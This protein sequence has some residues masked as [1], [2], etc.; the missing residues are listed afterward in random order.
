M[1]G[2]E[3]AIIT[4]FVADRNFLEGR[5]NC[6][7]KFKNKMIMILEE[8]EDFLF[9]YQ[10]PY[11]VITK[12]EI[13]VIDPERNLHSKIFLFGNKVDESRYSLR[14][15]IGSCNATISGFFRNIEFWATTTG[16]LDMPNTGK[17][18]LV[19]LLTS[20]D[21]DPSFISLEN[22]CKEEGNDKILSPT[23]DL[24]WRLIR[25][26]KGLDS[27]LEP[28]RSFCLS[29]KLV[30]QRQI[31]NA[32]FVHSL[33]DNSLWKAFEHMITS[34]LQRAEKE[35]SILVVSP[36]HNWQALRSL[37]HL[38]KR[39]LKNVNI[40]VQIK[41]LT[42]F[43][44][45]FQNRYLSKEA[46][47]DIEKL[48]IRDKKI[49]FICKVWTRRSEIKV[50]ELFEDENLQDVSSVFL[51]GKLIIVTNDKGECQALL[52]SPN[53][54][55][56]AIS[57]SPKLNLETAIW[58]RNESRAKEILSKAQILW[59]AA[60]NLSQNMRERLSEWQKVRSDVLTHSQTWIDSSRVI[61]EY[62][63]VN[64]MKK[65][66]PTTG[67]NVFLDELDDVFL[68][69][70]V[71]KGAPK[72]NLKEIKCVFLPDLDSSSL[73]EVKAR[74]SSKENLRIDFDF[75]SQNACR[76]F[77]KIL[78]PTKLVREVSVPFE[79]KAKDKIILRAPPF[80]S[81][82]YD[83]AILAKT[84]DG[85][86]EFSTVKEVNSELIIESLQEPIRGRYVKLRLY[87]RDIEK[88]LSVGWN[89]VTITKRRPR[90]EPEKSC[91]CASSFCV[92]LK[93]K[94]SENDARIF[95]ETIEV[96][97]PRKKDTGSKIHVI[98]MFCDLP[99]NCQHFFGFKGM[100][101]FYEGTKG[102]ATIRIPLIIRFIDE[103]SRLRSKSD[104]YQKVVCAPT[105]KKVG[106]CVLNNQVREIYR[107][108]S[109]ITV[110]N[111]PTKNNVIDK[112]PIHF[113]VKIPKE[114]SEFFS[115]NIDLVI[116]EWNI[117]QWGRSWG[118][119]SVTEAAV[120][121][122]TELV[123]KPKHMAQALK[124]DVDE[125]N[126]EGFLQVRFLLKL[127]SGWRIPIKIVLIP[128]QKTRN[129][130]HTIFSGESLWKNIRRYIK[131]R[132]VLFEEIAK[133]YYGEIAKKYPDVAKDIH[134]FYRRLR[135]GFFG[136]PFTIGHKDLEYQGFRM[137]KE[138]AE[139]LLTKVIDAIA[140]R[141]GEPFL[142]DKNNPK[143]PQEVFTMELKKELKAAIEKTCFRI[144][145]DFVIF[146]NVL[147]KK[148]GTDNSIWE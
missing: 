34:L 60:E 122:V 109:R 16:V 54:T 133:I 36:Y 93:E 37:I 20:D 137:S 1:D 68:S 52:G 57:T 126:F 2:A 31:P 66:R 97:L 33:G 8:G 21:V 61:K 90:I 116:A 24:I 105:V 136:V 48:D 40:R 94:R 56:A 148:L 67:R 86:R 139:L 145:N 87:S 64:L 28:G 11:I 6:S 142:S 83:L 95:P 100:N 98:N 59:E 91:I 29:D 47:A 119:P 42:T 125:L 73:W 112:A 50:S 69:V 138:E 102:N 58:E 135:W 99:Y 103:H 70:Q 7:Q 81:R 117:L 76:L 39:A 143:L 51:H 46:F 106:E 131:D 26:S 75:K 104:L 55:E 35:S 41:L 53:L 120:F 134:E 141:I 45:D 124:T 121:P 110:D 71:L 23:I 32:I 146:P 111:Y 92:K 96:S 14:C 113:R 3:F 13:P 19:E 49:D 130:L 17:E 72:I 123:V 147:I 118:G 10:P 25:D 89:F 127:K 44:P 63:R 5:L 114:I 88:N 78:V 144:A 101:P 128:I 27:G 74:L 107:A 80:S 30:N 18:N 79:K 140:K 22:Q 12:Q 43:P 4:T 65:G 132:K 38:C 129:Y 62:V 9:P 15:L 82:S 85:W 108:S 115:K 77:Y 84:V